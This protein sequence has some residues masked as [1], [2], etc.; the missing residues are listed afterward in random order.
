MIGLWDDILTGL[1]VQNKAVVLAGLD[2]SKSILRC[3]Y[4]EI[5][6]GYSR[7]GLSNWGIQM[8][9][10]FLTNRKMRVKI[11]NVMS[12]EKEITGGAVPGAYSISLPPKVVILKLQIT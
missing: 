12:D 9:A 2:F 3:S 6:T 7:L 1:D 10:A 4:Q 5:L 8:H 11:G